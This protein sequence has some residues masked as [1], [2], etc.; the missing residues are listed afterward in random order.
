MFGFRKCTEFQLMLTWNLQGLLQNQSLETILICIV[1]LCFPQNNIAQILHVW[2]MYEIKRAK[3]LSHAFD[4][5]ISAQANLFTDHKK[6]GLHQYEPNID[7]LEQFVSKQWISLQLIHF[8]LLQIDDNPCMGSRL[9][10]IH[11]SVVLFASSQYISTHF[12]AWP[13]I[14]RDHVEMFASCLPEKG[15]FS[16]APAEILDSNI[17]LKLSTTSLLVS[18]S[19]WVQPKST[20]SR[21]DVGSPKSTSFVS[22]FHIGS[23]FCFFP[24]NYMSSTYTDKNNPF[25]RWTKRHSQ[26]GIFSQPCFNRIFSNC[27]SHDS[28]TKR[29]PYRFRL[30][31][32]TGSSILDHDLVHLCRGRRIQMSQHFDLG[33]F[34]NLGASS[35]LTLV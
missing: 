9:W 3:R 11:F 10:I 21:N 28:P 30:R 31:R 2:W 23:R 27:L 13:S 12:F 18:H 14:S 1:V 22:I 4:H 6:T 34:K 19:R 17:F 7:I 33:I 16:F 20:W 8:L 15:S 24:A 32:T 35:I 25:P 26:F 5:F 29:W